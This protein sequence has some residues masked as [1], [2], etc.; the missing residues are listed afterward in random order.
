MGNLAVSGDGQGEER[1]Q[2]FLY[3]GMASQYYHQQRST[4]D[5]PED[6]LRHELGHA[7][8]HSQMPGMESFHDFALFDAASVAEYEAIVCR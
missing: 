7:V 1:M 6:H 5:D 3:D 4:Q 2:R 8:L